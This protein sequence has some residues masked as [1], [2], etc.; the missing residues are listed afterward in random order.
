MSYSQTMPSVHLSKDRAFEALFEKYRPLI[1]SSVYHCVYGQAWRSHGYDLE[2]L[3]QEARFALWRTA[4]GFDFSKVPVGKEPDAV[5]LSYLRKTI[6][7]RLLLCIKRSRN[8]TKHQILFENNEIPERSTDPNP[9]LDWETLRL[10]T[11]SFTPHEREFY[12]LY[13]DLG[14]S[15]NEIAERLGVCRNTITN[16]KREIFAKI[17]REIKQS[18]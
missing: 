7:R 4:E 1:Y 8:L 9:L 17:R 3:I 5:F 6:N 15:I 10:I 11:A 16:W 14:Y 2:D 18:V 13:I 12:H